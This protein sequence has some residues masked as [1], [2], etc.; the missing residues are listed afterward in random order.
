MRHNIFIISKLLAKLFPNMFLYNHAA[1][2]ISATAIGWFAALVTTQ[3]NDIF[4]KISW[5]G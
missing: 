3:I 5:W 1:S 4:I 2:N